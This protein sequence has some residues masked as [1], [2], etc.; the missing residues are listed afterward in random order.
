MV[1]NALNTA[2]PFSANVF[3]GRVSGP[4]MSG[5]SAILEFSFAWFPIEQEF[6][7]DEMIVRP[8]ARTGEMEGDTT[9]LSRSTGNA[10]DR[11]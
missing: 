10:A 2:L 8:A 6:W 1:E 11:I 7:D 3:L 5:E 4:I 9:I